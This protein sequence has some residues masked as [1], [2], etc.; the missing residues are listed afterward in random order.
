[1]LPENIG[2]KLF[3]GLPR[4]FI[5]L[6]IV[7]GALA[8]VAA[9]VGVGETVYRTAVNVQL[10]VNTGLAHLILESGHL[11]GLDKRVVGAV[12]CQHLGLDIFG[13]LWRGRGKAAMEADDAVHVSAAAG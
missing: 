9:V 1:M 12:Q 4:A 13:I 2:E 5:C 7:G 10:P 3:H 8:V 11:I 6:F